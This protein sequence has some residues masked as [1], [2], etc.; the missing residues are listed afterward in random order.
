MTTCHLCSTLGGLRIGH[1]GQAVPCDW[2]AGDQHRIEMR[3]TARQHA[4][5]GLVPTG[6]SNVLPWQEAGRTV[7]LGG[8]PQ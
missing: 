7:I 4:M 2:S 5:L 8:T 3:E 6:Q 1:S